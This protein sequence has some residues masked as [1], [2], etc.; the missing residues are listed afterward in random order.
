M[1]ISVVSVRI[2]KELKDRMSS[3]QEDWASYLRR[4]IEHRIKQHERMEAS[5]VIDSIRAK[6]KQGRYI[7]AK[8]IREDRDRK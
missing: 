3:L 6:T 8:T 2:P 4:M 1:T 7:A 5:G